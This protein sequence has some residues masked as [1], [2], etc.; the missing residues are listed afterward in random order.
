M[1]P[2]RANRRYG[3]CGFCPS[4]E[5]PSLQGPSCCGKPCDHSYIEGCFA[6]G[7]TI[8]ASR[9]FNHYCSLSITFL[10]GARTRSKIRLLGIWGSAC[11]YHQL[12]LSS[13]AEER[14]ANLLKHFSWLWETVMASLPVSAK[15]IEVERSRSLRLQIHVHRP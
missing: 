12:H 2:I 6:R 4:F 10:I 13:Q 7:A 5:I 14:L 8:F 11:T 15:W 3:R 1:I 9:H